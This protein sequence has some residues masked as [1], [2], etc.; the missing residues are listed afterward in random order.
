LDKLP[1]KYREAF[2]MSRMEGLKTQKNKSNLLK[3]TI[4][5]RLGKAL[6]L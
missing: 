2:E 3:R 1:E 6:Q 5:V 4:E